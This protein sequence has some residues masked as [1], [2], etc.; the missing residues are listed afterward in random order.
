[1]V[2]FC[3]LSSGNSEICVLLSQ[4]VYPCIN[5]T[6][7]RPGVKDVIVFVR[8]F[9][10]LFHIVVTYGVRRVGVGSVALCGAHFWV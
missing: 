1:M 5:T 10:L 2:E 8:V 7:I 9:Y 3:Q 4:A 6:H